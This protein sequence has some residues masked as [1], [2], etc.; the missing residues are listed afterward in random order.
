MLSGTAP[1]DD[2]SQPRLFENI[3]AGLFSF[4]DPCWAKISD[5]AKTLIRRML[6]VDV[7]RRITLDQIEKSEWLDKSKKSSSKKKRK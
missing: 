3:R 4:D 2:D 6:C 1:F 7:K 5:S